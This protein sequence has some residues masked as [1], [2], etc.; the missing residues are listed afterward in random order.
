MNLSIRNR[1]RLAQFAALSLFALFLG[2]CDNGTKPVTTYAVGD[3]G[4]AGGIVFFDNGSYT[5]DS[6]GNS[7]RYLECA[8]ADLDTGI[9]WGPNNTT[10]VIA[11]DDIGAGAANTAAILAAY[12][13]AATAANCA[14]K[15]CDEYSQGGYGDWFLPNASEL[16]AIYENLVQ[17]GLGDFET[18]EGSFYWS[19]IQISP[20]AIYSCLLY[21]NGVMRWFASSPTDTGSGTI[22][23]HVRPIRSF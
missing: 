12:G 2:S 19:S 15:A 17:Q 14:A 21:D 20:A 10:T 22:S 6:L 11:S 16:D 1:S 13:G 8:P 3:T 23:R 4:P 7:W 18:T 9:S 5:D